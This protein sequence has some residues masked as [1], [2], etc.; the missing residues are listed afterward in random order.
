MSII[1]AAIRK[2]NADAEVDIIN[3][4]INSIIWH[5]GTDPISVADI[6][7]QIPIVE[8]EMA[9]AKALVISKKASAKAK[10]L[11]LGL[12]ED[13]IKALVGYRQDKDFLGNNLIFSIMLQR[14]VQIQE[15]IVDIDIQ[16]DLKAA[17]EQ[18]DLKTE[19]LSRANEELNR[20]TN[21]RGLLNQQVQSLNFLVSYLK[22][23]LSSEEEIEEVNSEV[24]VE[25]SAEYPPDN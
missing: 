21:T 17:L 18:L 25:R 11:A 9:D 2:I 12:D 10:L 13:E 16:A 24:P 3:E 6:Q 14:Q 15:A 4:D 8:Q 23:K 5:T 7:E 1:V 20:A 22:S 19:E